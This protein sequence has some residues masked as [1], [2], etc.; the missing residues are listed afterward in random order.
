MKPRQPVTQYEVVYR[1]GASLPH[2]DR[3][4]G[5]FGIVNLDRAS[6]AGGSNS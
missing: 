1:L 2:P 6:F 3:A 4:A 5:A